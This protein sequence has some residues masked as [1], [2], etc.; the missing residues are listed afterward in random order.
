MTREEEI[1]EILR[2]LTEVRSISDTDQE[3]LAGDY[4]EERLKNQVYFQKQRN[5]QGQRPG[6]ILP[7]AGSYA[8]DGDYLGRKEIGRAHV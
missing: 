8:V 3:Y 7:P 5:S 1:L 4:I 2:E 6:E